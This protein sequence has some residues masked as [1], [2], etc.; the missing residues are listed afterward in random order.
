MPS[1][2]YF[3]RDGQH[4]RLWGFERIIGSACEHHVFSIDAGAAWIAELL[5]RDVSRRLSCALRELRRDMYEQGWR[6]AKARR[7][8]QTKFFDGLD[9]PFEG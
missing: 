7:P 6:D 8:K 5:I 2:L 9:V 1:H 3:R 4:V